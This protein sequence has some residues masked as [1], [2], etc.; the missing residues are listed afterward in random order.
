MSVVFFFLKERNKL[1]TDFL[2]NI[3]LSQLHKKLYEKSTEVETGS[4][5]Y[6]PR[7]LP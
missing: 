3:Y 1:L 6:I 4:Y 7:N 5:M 2:T